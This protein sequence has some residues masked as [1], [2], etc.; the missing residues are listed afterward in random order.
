MPNKLKNLLSKKL[1][2]KQQQRPECTQK[3]DTQSI[4]TLNS[5]TVD[6]CRTEITT[7]NKNSRLDTT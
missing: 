3:T 6:N 5:Q 4:T 1:T 2:K 7:N